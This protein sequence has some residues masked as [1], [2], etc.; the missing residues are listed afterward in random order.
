MIKRLSKFNFKHPDIVS[1]LAYCVYSGTCSAPKKL[2]FSGPAIARIKPIISK[3]FKISQ[4]ERPTSICGRKTT[5]RR[6]YIT[7]TRFIQE[8]K[9]QGWKFKLREINKIP[10]YVFDDVNLFKTLLSILLDTRVCLSFEFGVMNRKVEMSIESTNIEEWSTVRCY[11]QKRNL[12]IGNLRIHV[13]KGI[14]SAEIKWRGQ[15]IY[16]IMDFIGW[17]LQRPWNVTMMKYMME[18]RE[19]R[20][21]PKGRFL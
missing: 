8:A 7:A 17:N 6:A 10:S 5:E 20:N 12:P 19:A 3:Y 18:N 4:Y 16:K 9:I 2:F 14:Q 13:L 21:T 1:I 11:L 15:N